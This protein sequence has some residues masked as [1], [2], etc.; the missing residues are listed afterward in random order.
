M[1]DEPACRFL[2]DSNVYDRLVETPEIQRRAIEAHTSGRIELLRTHVQVDELERD[3]D[4]APYTLAIPGTPVPTYGLVLGVSKLGLAR[5]GETA[6][7]DAIRSPQRN[8]TH[9]ALLATTAQYEG[10]I[11]VT[12]DRRL[13]RRAEGEGIEV[14]DADRFIREALGQ[15]ED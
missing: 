15:P 7:I 6:K 8:H 12:E 9:D 10:A 13:R 5:F 2:L 14:W 4:K 3:I 11:L 1:S